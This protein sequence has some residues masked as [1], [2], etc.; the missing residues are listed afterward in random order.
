MKRSRTYHQEIMDAYAKAKAMC[1]AQHSSSASRPTTQ[2]RPSGNTNVLSSCIHDKSHP[3]FCTFTVILG[4]NGI[5]EV[6]QLCPDLVQ[7]C[8]AIYLADDL[9]V[10]HDVWR[11]E[12][13]RLAG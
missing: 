8:G 13:D 9:E 2:Q 10:P 4:I 6:P 7:K 1:K 3:S 5:W 12:R 11:K